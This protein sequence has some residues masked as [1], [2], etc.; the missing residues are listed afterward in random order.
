MPPA[1]TGAVGTAEITF[2]G[3][4]RIELSARLE[5]DGF[6][7]L[8]ETYYPGWRAQVDGHPVPVLRADGVLRAVYVPAGTHHVRFTFFPMSLQV[9]AAI[10][11]AT[12]LLVGVLF[13]RNGTLP[14]LA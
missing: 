8:S 9:G 1:G 10:S 5:R 6:L 7:V 11:A 14:L 13:V 4:N 3:I 12:L 2:T